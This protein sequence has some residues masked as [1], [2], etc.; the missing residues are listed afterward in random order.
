[1]RFALFDRPA[2]AGEAATTVAVA[3]RAALPDTEQAFRDPEVEDLAFTVD[4][5]PPDA[6]VAAEAAD[7][8]DT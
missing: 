5:D 7:G 4:E 6:G 1:M 3:H 8:L 2:T